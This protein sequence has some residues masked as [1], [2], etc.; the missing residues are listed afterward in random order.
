MKNLIICLLITLCLLETVNSRL[1]WGK[2]KSI[3]TVDN[4]DASQYDGLW[5]E[6]R[7]DAATKFEKGGT[8]TTAEYTLND[9]GSLKVYNS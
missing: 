4:F 7:R 3:T 2:C 6:M 9:D 5:Y 1:S 8:C